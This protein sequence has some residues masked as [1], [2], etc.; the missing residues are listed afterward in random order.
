MTGSI[1]IASTLAPRVVGRIGAR[2]TITAGMA[3]ATVGIALLVGIAPDGSYL[4][5]VFPG[6][7]LSAIGMGFSLVPATIVA[8][9]CLPASQ[10][11]IGSGL[12]NTSRLMGGALGLAVLST[13][14][15]AQTRAN[16]GSGAAHALTSGFDLAFAVGAGLSLVGALVA[17]LRLRSSAAADREAASPSPEELA[18]VQE[19][20]ALAA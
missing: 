14:A 17:G 19:S 20:E 13:I 16:A 15:D 7:L 1:F 11:G 8:M 12:L 2:A 4:G 6:A 18:E 5:S 9:Q 10:S 3:V